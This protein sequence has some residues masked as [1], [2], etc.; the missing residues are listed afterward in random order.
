MAKAGFHISVSSRSYIP[1]VDDD[2]MQI[3]MF[4]AQ[5]ISRYVE[6]GSLDCGITV[7][8]VD[9]GI[10]TGP[11]IA[12]ETVPVLAGDTE[13][14]L[15][16]RISGSRTPPLSARH[17]CARR[18]EDR[19]ERSPNGL[20]IGLTAPAARD[21]TF[22]SMEAHRPLPRPTSRR[23]GRWSVSATARLVPMNPCI[24]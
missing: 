21:R 22:G 19:G 3:R 8:F 4:R 5:E 1:Y 17:R 12:Q 9:Q 2:E 6:L 10:D 23:V 14:K 16:A 20:A 15:H 7:H 24:V 11:I 13:E 18:R